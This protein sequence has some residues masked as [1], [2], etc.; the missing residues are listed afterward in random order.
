MLKVAEAEENQL[1]CCRNPWGQGEWTGKWGVQDYMANSN[2][3]DYARIF[4]PNWNKV[5]VY[6]KFQTT[7]LMAKAVQEHA[8]EADD[9]I[10]F[11]VGDE[12]PVE[13][14]AGFWWEGTDKDG[15]TGFFPG[16]K[17]TLVARPVAK[18]ELEGTPDGEKPVKAVIILTQSNVLLQ[19]KFYKRKEDGLNYK[20]TSYNLM[21]I[22]VYDAE[23]KKLFAKQADDR[24]VWNELALPPGACSIFVT[25]PGGKGGAFSV[26][27]F[28]K[29][30]AAR[31]TSVE[32]AQIEDLMAAQKKAAELKAAGAAEE[33]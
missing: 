17:A 16:E 29:N 12:I 21:R 1:V 9:E 25:S 4:G 33:G 30:G 15:K 14:F 22:E 32:G 20:D 18:Y 31:L 8:A 24:T 13:S 27:V 7:G 2:G 28:F 11:A 26:R 19:R 10:S 3:A 5:T 23:G 6:S